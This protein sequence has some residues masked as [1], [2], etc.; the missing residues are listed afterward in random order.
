MTASR[1]PFALLPLLTACAGGDWAVTTWGEDYIE[2]GIPAAEFEDGC[3]AHFDSFT[4]ALAEVALLDGD[5][6]VAASVPGGTFA[7]TEPGPHAV[8]ETAV[9]AGEYAA[10]RFVVAPAGGES[11]HTAGTLTCGADAV[12]FDWSFA[13]TST[14]RCS[15][16]DLG[17][18]AKG[19]LDTEFTVHGDH[20][21]YDGLEDADAGLQGLPI[22]QADADGDGSV[23]LD[24]LSAVS[25]AGLGHTVGQYSE[26]TDLAAF[27]THLT[28]T[29][30]H[31]DGEGHCE[32]DL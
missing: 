2:Q 32:V 23:T 18:P 1:L 9:A 26:V 3:A 31:V 7:L 29:L 25:I 24:E 19:G 6:E 20:L 13:T 12:D 22:L 28:R 17:V 14:Y 8:G 30:G 10:A 5:G 21:F 15:A 11:V 4:V 16:T 27:V